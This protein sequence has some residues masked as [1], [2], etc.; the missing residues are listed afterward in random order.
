MG[1]IEM[2]YNLCLFDLDGTL[3]DSKLGII[4]SFQY[5]L[6]SFGIY[7]EF[8]NLTKYLGPPIRDSFR[9]FF[10]SSDDD[11]EKAVAKYR[12]Y[13]AETGLFENTV[14]PGT[15][16]MLQE[17]KS[18]GL[19]LSVATSKVTAYAGRIL[20]HFNLDKYFSFISGDKMDGSLSKDGK[21]E[22]LRIA[23]NALDPE[24]KMNAGIIGDRKHDIHGGR[25]VGIDSIGITW[26]YGSRAELE[27]AGATWITEST[28]DLCRLI[29][30]EGAP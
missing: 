8:D 16:E 14:Y 5:A 28:D 12:E 13:F 20:S 27:E 26:G 6:S 18:A 15:I 4:K 10:G 3:T 11:V 22:I 30:T 23:L 1:F 21:R 2:R 17:L 7:E 19:L 29:L 9:D 24:R 25:K